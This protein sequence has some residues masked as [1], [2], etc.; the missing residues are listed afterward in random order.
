MSDD[1][2]EVVYGNGIFV[3]VGDGG[4]IATSTDGI[5]LTER[6]SGTSNYINDIVFQ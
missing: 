1:L 2:N 4:E 3:V 5:T 6:T